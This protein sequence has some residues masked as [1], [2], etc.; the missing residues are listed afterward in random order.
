MK[1]LIIA[2]GQGQRLRTGD[3][4]RPK[5][6]YKVAG[7]SLIE[8]AILSSKRA[9]I[10][11]FVIVTGYRGEEIREHLSRRQRKLGVALSFV[12]NPDWEKPNGH[13]VLKAKALLQD[14]FIL[15]MSDHIFDWR[16]LTGLLEQKPSDGEIVLAVDDRVDEIFDIDDA[17]KVQTVDSRIREIGKEI[18]DYNAIDTGIFYCSPGIFTALE[19]V[20]LK[21][22]G[23]LSEAIGLLASEGKAKTHRIGR[24]F[25]QDVDTPTSLKQAEKV[26]FRS[27]R[28]DTDG[29]VSRYFNRKVSGFISRLLVKTPLTP[30]VVTWSALVIGSLSG[31]F[32]AHGSHWA[33]AIGGL[34]F[35]FA[36]IYDGCDGEVAKLKLASSKFG[37]WL[38]TVVDNVTYLIFFIGVIV[39]AT[40]QGYAYILPIG[41]LTVFGVTM[42]LS[43]MYLYLARFTNSGSLVTVQNDLTKDLEVE[44]QSLFIRMVTKIKFM[45]KRDFFALLFMTFCLFNRLDGILIL[46]AIGSNLTWIVFLTMKR[47]FAPAKG[48]LAPDVLEEQSRV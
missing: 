21:A 41:I 25:W 47:E 35:Q 10:S 4:D 46:S 28:K 34:V 31:F 38:D 19:E 33:V 5:P 1:A 7:V 13:S 12:D 45:M 18:S 29:V 24:A 39:G 11:E 30:N 2:A 23:S 8:R 6:L 9:G 3:G 48:G 43:T 20:C 42:C 44:G 37:E 14:D 26:L 17:T 40:R 22:K 36:S 27:V 15:L 32:I 16:I